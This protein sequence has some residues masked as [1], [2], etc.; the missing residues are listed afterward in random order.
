MEIDG[1]RTFA[2]PDISTPPKTTVSNVCSLPGLGVR[3]RVIG[4]E[5]RVGARFLGLGGRRADIQSNTVY[6]A[7]FGLGRLGIG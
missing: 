5:F 1:V 4:L 2:P 3:F 6:R 7:S